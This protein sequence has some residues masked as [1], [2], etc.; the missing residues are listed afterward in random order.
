MVGGT[1]LDGDTA[2]AAK[3][4][5]HNLALGELGLKDGTNAAPPKEQRR[6]HG[7]ELGHRGV[8]ADDHAAAAFLALKQKVSVLDLPAPP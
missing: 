6:L 8:V 5:T 2:D 3:G 4:P 1:A 7:Q